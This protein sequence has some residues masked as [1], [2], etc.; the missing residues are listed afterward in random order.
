MSAIIRALMPNDK[1]TILKFERM[2]KSLANGGD[3]C[4]SADEPDFLEW[5]APWRE[6]SL[7]HYL[8]LG[9][10]F[11]AFEGEKLLG[12]Y[13]AQPFLF[14]NGSTQT[15]WLEHVAGITEAQKQELIVVAHT[16]C[17]EK[18][19]QCLLSRDEFLLN[20]KTCINLFSYATVRSV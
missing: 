20:K 10:S 17:R 11:G 12:Y 15:L 9:W 8:P 4:S 6:E 5:F 16:L 3:Q 18:H 1:E 2:L 19:F 7:D 14:L 13:L